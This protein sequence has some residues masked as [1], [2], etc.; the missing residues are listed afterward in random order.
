M[1]RPSIS[2]LE[3][4]APVTIE[5]VYRGHAVFR[6]T[7]P[8][9]VSPIS[10]VTVGALQGW[11]FT[12]RYH[13][14]NAL[15]VHNPNPPEPTKLEHFDREYELNSQNGSYSINLSCPAPLEA[16]CEPVFERFLKSVR[17]TSQD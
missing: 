16:K 12:R 15:R 17:V 7:S 8:D 1:Y 11:M 4:K 13:N 5:K 10:E 3:L 2:V 9:E 6:K 14:A